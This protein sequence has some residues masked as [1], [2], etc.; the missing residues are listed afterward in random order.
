MVF[1]VESETYRARSRSET[2]GD[3]VLT[4]RMRG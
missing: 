1:D 4:E 3:S 2:N